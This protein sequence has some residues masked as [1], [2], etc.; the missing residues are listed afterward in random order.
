MKILVV[1]GSGFVGRHICKEAL[2]RG[3]HVSSLSRHGMPAATAGEEWI[4]GVEWIKGDVFNTASYSSVLPHVDGAIHSLGIL[5]ENSSYKVL[6]QNAQPLKCFQNTF[7]GIKDGKPDT[8]QSNTYTYEQANRDSALALALAC[9]AHLNVK[10]FAYISASHSIAPFIPKRYITTKMEAENGISS[11]DRYQLHIFRPGLMYSPQRPATM[12]LSSLCGVA[13]SLPFLPAIIP[14]IGVKPLP[15]AKV[16]FAVVDAM[17]KGA[18]SPSEPKTSVYE[19]S[20]L[21]SQ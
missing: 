19:V 17:E 11:L 1:G 18:L 6:L 13:G 12:A 7:L 2:Q 14:W 8:I 15:V 3:W 5:F 9:R 16:G 21:S 4:D 10:Q 20:D